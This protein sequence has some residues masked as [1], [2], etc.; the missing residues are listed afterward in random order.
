MGKKYAT[1][2]DIQNRRA[3][4]HHLS[5]EDMPEGMRIAGAPEEE[6]EQW[7]KEREADEESFMKEKE[8]KWAEIQALMFGL[9][10]ILVVK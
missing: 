8:A 9:N 7:V 4:F 6:I 10:Y 2:E 3:F 5:P 1:I